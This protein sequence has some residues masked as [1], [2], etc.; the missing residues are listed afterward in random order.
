MTANGGFFLT[1]LLSFF[2]PYPLTLT[3]P[4]ELLPGVD[5][6]SLTVRRRHLRF[7]T[8]AASTPVAERLDELQYLHEEGP[9]VEA[10]EASDWRRSPDL[11]RDDRWATWGRAAAQVGVRSVLSVG[12][13][14]RGERVGTAVVT[15]ELD[16]HAEALLRAVGDA[17]H[18]LVLTAHLGVEDVA[19]IADEVAPAAE[20]LLETVRRLQVDGH[21]VL[22]VA[23]GEGSHDLPGRGGA[24]A[25]AADAGPAHPVEQAHDRHH[26]V[27]GGELGPGEHHEG[28]GDAEH[29]ALDELAERGVRGLERPGRGQH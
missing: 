11:S 9:C 2:Q 5:H 19:G 8:P 3:T 27:A 16:P 23:S 15:D 14:A 1:N 6:A 21:G 17:G 20:T 13:R 28:Q 25:G 18:R 12:M 26:H 29:Q 10:Y 7:H 22:L 4:T 24:G